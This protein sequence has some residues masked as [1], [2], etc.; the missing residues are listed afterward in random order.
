EPS[1]ADLPYERIVD[2]YDDLNYDVNYKIPPDKSF[3][4]SSILRVTY[5]DGVV[6]EF[7]VD[8]DFSSAPMTY[9][10]AREALAHAKVGRGGRIVPTVMN[11][12]TTPRLWRARAD[13]LQA[14]DAEAAVFMGMA[15]APIAFVLSVPAMPAGALPE[16]AVMSKGV[17]RRAVPATRV[18]PAQI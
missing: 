17:T 8:T 9:D 2:A 6:V 10:Q 1:V 4:F 7:D 14:Q 5:R 12:L 18:P 3:A 16:G 11:V 13:A 15:L